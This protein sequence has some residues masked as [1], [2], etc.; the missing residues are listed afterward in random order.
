MTADEKTG[1]A[2]HG[3]AALGVWP[4]CKGDIYGRDADVRASRR[5]GGIGRVNQAPSGH[6]AAPAIS[7]C[8]GGIGRVNQAPSG[9]AA[10]PAISRRSFLG[11]TA[12][13]LTAAGMLGAHAFSPR[14]AQADEATFVYGT[15]GYG[16]EMDDAGLNPHANYSGWSCVRY[17]VGE[18][19]FRLSDAM[20]PEGW[21]AESWE[22]ADDTHLR[23]TLRP[24]VRFS[25]GRELDAQ[26]VK[27]CLDDLMATHDRAPGDLQIESVEAQGSELVIATSQPK[28]SLVNFLCDP[29]AAVIDMQAGVTAEG[30]VAGTGPYVATSVSDSEVVLAANP[31]YWGGA[32]PCPGVDVRAITDGDTLTMALQAGTVHASYGLPYASYALFEGAGYTVASCETSRVFFAQAN[33]ASSVMQDAAVRQALAM[34]IDKQGF[35]D[36]LLGGRGAVATG[37]FPA[38]FAFG[39]DAVS[40]PAYDPEAAKQLLEQAGWVDS[41]GD[42]VREKDGKRLHIVWL[43][44]PGRV[45][46][47]LLAESAQFSLG[48]IGFE[49]EVQCTANHTSL[50]TD[51]SAWDVYAS[52][53][54]TAPTG[55]P[56]SFFAATCLT[57]A[58]KNFGGY[59]NPELDALADE[60]ACEF[61]SDRRRE[62]AV[63]MQQALVDD[64]AFVFASHLTMGIVSRPGVSGMA[65]HPCDFYEVSADLALG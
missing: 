6:A 12:A 25:S 18:T 47:P 30:N 48:E 45:E 64:G 9:H 24:G 58:P 38:S 40:A 39:G 62:L 1:L 7:R 20:E 63:Q 33:Y 10:A 4:T 13:G 55:D 53:L 41:D 65:A 60:L 56:E 49:V 17:G 27:E 52:A 14:R 29:Y 22:F 42:G 43:T 32:V 26:A 19:L 44:Y 28:P 61:D 23:V 8:S 11:L 50:R 15:T 16:P 35:V 59:T 37:A 3:A 46:L 36:V 34:G 21:L 57:G 54:V 31:D 51:T 5:S 2:A